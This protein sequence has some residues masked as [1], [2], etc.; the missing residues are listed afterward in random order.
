VRGLIVD[1]T[2]QRLAKE[3]MRFGIGERERALALETELEAEREE[4][5]ELRALD[6]MKNTF[7]AA[8][9]HDL[10]TPLA[11]ILGLAVTL[12]RHSL[13]EDE[14]KELAS[15]I[16]ANA[17][18]LDRL[19]TD[20]LDLDRLS[21]GIVEPS[22][23]AVDVGAL[24]VRVVEDSDVVVGRAI[25]IRSEHVVAEIDAA[26]VERIAENLLANAA[27][28]TPPDAR[29][30]VTVRPDAKGV[31]IEVEDDGPGVPADQ[32]QAIFQPF[33]QVDVVAHSPGVGIGLALVGRFAELH[34]GRAW[35]EDRDGG[36]ASFRV[37][38]PG[39]PNAEV[40][41]GD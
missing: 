31:L 39:H 28:H 20:L 23:R 27:R 4:S 40:G 19:V 8:V 34:G 5:A 14:A 11:A 10:R 36:G 37:W 13:D 15:R 18:R 21:R 6:E 25:S 2:R 29:I 33:R 26:K 17:R 38:L 41:K 35:V 32:R 3:R 24:V 22:L 1:I 30:W 9:S 16:A 12:E 7:L